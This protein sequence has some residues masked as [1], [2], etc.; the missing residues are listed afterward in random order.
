[1]AGALNFIGRE[2]LYGR[3]WGCVEDHPCLHFELCYYQAIDFAIAQG[4]A[5]V[6]AG[7]QGEH[8]LARGYLPVRPIRCTG[9]PMPGFSDAIARYLRPNA[10][11]DEE[12]EVLTSYGPFRKVH[13]RN[14]MTEKLTDAE[15]A[16]DLTPLLEAA[17]PMVEGR[18]AIPRPSSSDFV[19]AF[20]WMTRAAL[21]AEKMEP[22]PEWSTSTRPSR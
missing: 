7:A 12:I 4:L 9:W 22:P 17:G 3:Y 21:L 18:D 8:K 6:E 14:R 19:E 10:R 15:R 13:R 16:S 5:R 2:T 11:V 1:V 20:G